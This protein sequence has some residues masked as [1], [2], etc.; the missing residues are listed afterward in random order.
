[1][2]SEAYYQEIHFVQGSLFKKVGFKIVQFICQFIAFSLQGSF[3]TQET[4]EC[5]NSAVVL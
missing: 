4:V 1:M 3:A 2:L 5:I